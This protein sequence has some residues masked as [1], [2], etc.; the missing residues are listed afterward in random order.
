MF[1]STV[2]WGNSTLPWMAYPTE[3]RSSTGSSSDVA[4]PCTNT[5]PSSG[6]TSAFTILRSVVLPH[7][8]LPMT[9]TNKPSSTATLTSSTAM[10]LPNRLVAWWNATAGGSTR[11]APARGTAF[12]P[13]FAR[14]M[15][16]RPAPARGVSL[17]PASAR[18]ASARMFSR[19]SIYISPFATRNSSATA[20]GSRL[21]VSTSLFMRAISSFEMAPFSLSSSSCSSG[22]AASVSRRTTLPHR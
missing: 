17:R 11:S 21:F 8:E 1:C 9:V 10:L 22:C 13:A 5:L 14:G 7:P 12:R 2:R 20:R 3:R 15:P 18:P 16:A 19:R 4:R 6:M